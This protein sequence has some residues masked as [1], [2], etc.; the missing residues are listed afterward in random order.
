MNKERIETILRETLRDQ[1]LSRSEKRA[2]SQVFADLTPDDQDRALLRSIA[3]DLARE[4]IE[5]NKR[6]RNVLDWL[7]QVVKVIVNAEP[8]R[9]PVSEAHFSPGDAPLHRIVALLLAARRSV[10]VC[11]F[12][13]TDD[14]IARALLD[15]HKRGVTL[16]II[17]DNDKAFD[18]GSDI[19]KLRAAGVPVRVDRTD[20]HMHHKFAV[21]DRELLLTGSYN[22]T[23]SAANQNYENIIVT[24]DARLATT[25]ANVFEQYWDELE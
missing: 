21:F 4:Q 10:D 12:A 1:H 24:D 11:V 6:N 23:R 17:S 22:W 15:C 9:G 16:R 13:I 2:L 25:F 19:D 7:E 3:F 18:R 8:D 20:A 5:S 14:R